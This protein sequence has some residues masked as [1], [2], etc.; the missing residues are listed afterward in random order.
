[1]SCMHDVLVEFLMVVVLFH[2]TPVFSVGSFCSRQ[3]D[4]A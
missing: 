1:M 4:N 2:W 3:L